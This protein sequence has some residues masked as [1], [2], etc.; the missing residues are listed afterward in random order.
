MGLVKRIYTDQETI[1]TAESM[2]NIQDAILDLEDGLFAVDNNK[3][4]ELITITDASKR[5]FR[6]FNI[7]GKTT[8]DGTPTL[9]APVDL[10]SVGDSGSLTATVCGKN[11]LQ[12]SIAG[13]TYTN[14]G[15][16]VTF[17]KDGYVANGTPTRD[18]VIVDTITNLALPK[19]TYYI[20][21]GTGGKFYAQV[22]VTKDGVK[23][24]Y[25]NKAF[26]IDGT[27]TSVEVS[28]QTGTVESTGTL[29]NYRIYPM[30]VVGSTAPTEYEA[31]KDGGSVTIS[32]PGG[33][34]GIPVTS[35]GNYTDANGQQWVCDE[36][37]FA[38][39]VY[40]QRVEKVDLGNLVWDYDYSYYRFLTN[41]LN[42]NLKNGTRTT[43]LMTSAGYDCKYRS[44]R[45]VD[46]DNAIYVAGETVYIHDA[47]YTTVDAFT[48]AVTGTIL[49]YPF[50]TPIE[51][52]LPEEELAAYASLHTYKGHTTV[53]NDGFAYMELEYVMD[54]KKYIDS[55]LA[56]P[57]AKLT[58]VTLRAS[59]WKGADSLYSQ[60]VAIAGIT[61]YSKVDLLPSVEQLAIFY[62]KDVAFVTENEDGVVTVYAIGDKPTLDYT[63][64]AQITEVK[65]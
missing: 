31:Y 17:D 5:G 61:E 52:P 34:P 4:G 37:D 14:G 38:R 51:T 21:G 19:G 26:S 45:L 47:N 62:S 46:W 60:V 1:I 15:I 10:V 23:S 43:M 25:I 18:Y 29:N 39:G 42:K 7:Y 6:S 33:L 59:A 30:L 11:L 49:L 50:K 27:E 2:N 55:M 12:F 48:A 8:Q 16:T 32:T 36:I 13:N 65:V 57:P 63:M 44:E 56:E 9:D 54:A 41:S 28:L 64:Q 24:Y 22:I 58:Q 53:S 20:S 35:G 40:V 3:S